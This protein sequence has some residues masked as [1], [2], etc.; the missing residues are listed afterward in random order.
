MN[1]SLIPSGV[2]HAANFTMFGSRQLCTLYIGLF[3]DTKRFTC[4]DCGRQ[5]TARIGLVGHSRTHSK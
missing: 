4:D 2:K 3:T 1:K 5:F